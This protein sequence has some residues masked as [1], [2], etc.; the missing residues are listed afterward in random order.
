MWVFFGAFRGFLIIILFHLGFL[1]LIG[2]DKK[3]P[4][5]LLEAYSY[6]YI[7]FSAELLIKIFNKPELKFDN[8]EVK[9]S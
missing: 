4:D 9:E 5:T 8:D 6:E 1:Y 3:I 7:N 2:K